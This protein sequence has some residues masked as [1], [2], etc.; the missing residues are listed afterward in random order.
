MPRMTQAHRALLQFIAKRAR[1]EMSPFCPL[2]SLIDFPG[3]KM[4]IKDLQIMGLVSVR[5]DTVSL[6]PYGW[7]WVCAISPE[8]I[9]RKSGR[10]RQFE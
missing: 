2:E 6:S 1:A 4:L 9:R 7:S 3:F 5:G 10:K 8:I